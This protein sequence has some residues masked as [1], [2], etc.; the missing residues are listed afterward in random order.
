MEMEWWALGI[1]AGYVESYVVVWMKEKKAGSVAKLEG[2]PEM[3]QVSREGSESTPN[4]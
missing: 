1:Y 3:P 2:L 4:F